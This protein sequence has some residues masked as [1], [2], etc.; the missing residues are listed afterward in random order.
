MLGLYRNLAQSYSKILSD[1]FSGK[2]I[3]EFTAK[4]K[5]VKV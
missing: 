1:R 4:F 3:I 5:L 2:W